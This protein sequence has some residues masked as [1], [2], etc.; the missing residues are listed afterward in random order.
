MTLY[1][2][3]SLNYPVV[4]A[5]FMMLYELYLNLQQIEK[6]QVKAL[7]NNIGL[8]HLLFSSI[9]N[10]EYLKFTISNLSNYLQG[11]SHL[12]VFPSN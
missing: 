9:E 5:F 7:Q 6:L 4:K 12:L 1:K 8:I 10:L 3:K 2:T 11:F